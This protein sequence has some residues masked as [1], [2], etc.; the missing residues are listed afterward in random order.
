M[1]VAPITFNFYRYALTTESTVVTQMLFL[2]ILRNKRIIKFPTT[3]A[4]VIQFGGKS[5]S[6]IGRA[7]TTVDANKLMILYNLDSR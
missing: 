7:V 1:P 3:Y 4:K 5:I 2:A 6:R